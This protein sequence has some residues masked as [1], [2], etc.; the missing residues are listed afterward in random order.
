[1]A[2]RCKLLLPAPPKEDYLKHKPHMLPSPARTAHI[3]AVTITRAHDPKSCNC[4]SPGPVPCGL[5]EAA[6]TSHYHKKMHQISSTFGRRKGW[7][8][9]HTQK[10][11]IFNTMTQMKFK[12]SKPKPKKTKTSAVSRGKERNI[13]EFAGEFVCA[14]PSQRGVVHWHAHTDDCTT[15]TLRT[16][17]SEGLRYIVNF[18]SKGRCPAARSRSQSL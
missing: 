16:H 1:M 9:K 11:V 18:S 10:T 14:D 2:G 13:R 5:C 12:L 17:L 6:W 8:K 15:N 4:I 3:P 7:G